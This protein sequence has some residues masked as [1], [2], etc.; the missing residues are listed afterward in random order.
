MRVAW[1]SARIFARLRMDEFGPY[2]EVGPSKSQVI[3]V[4]PIYVARSPS[5]RQ[6]PLFFKENAQTLIGSKV[7][8]PIRVC[9]MTDH[10]P[11]VTAQRNGCSHD[12]GFSSRSYFL[13]A[14]FKEAYCPELRVQFW[15]IAGESNIADPLSRDP[16][17]Q[18]IRQMRFVRADVIFPDLALAHHPFTQP[19]TSR[20]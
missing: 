5:L 15:H 20:G 18:S 19:F 14:L 4:I 6:L 3:V 1:V 8:R 9:F 10:E 16:C 11:I 2:S 7:N 12:G 17:L 13:N